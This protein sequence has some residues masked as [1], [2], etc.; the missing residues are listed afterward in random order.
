M[1]ARKELA[2]FGAAYLLYN[3]GRWVTNGDMGLALSNA[4]A[5]LDLQGG[6]GV[7]HAV[8][9]ALGGVW[10]T[11]LSHVYLAAQI[12]VLPGALLAIYRWAPRIYPRLRST[13]IATWMLSL[14]VYALFP[15]A[16]PR[17]AG[18]GM[19]DAVSETSAVALAGHSTIFYNPIAAVPSLHCG[20]AAALSIAV[21]A[22]VKRRWLKLAVL[23]WG[24]LVALSTV[25]TGNHYVF[26][27]AA[28][29]VV[30]ALGYLAVTCSL[31][32]PVLRPQVAT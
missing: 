27:V 5:V 25:A 15:V 13:V 2:L 26:D 23:A 24:P 14:P 1:R 3:A 22:A 20:F 18:I 7:E 6:D 32:I 28:G 30:T 17:L 19:D 21:A 9:N 8:Q 4:Q 10:M 31:R 12:I 11:L 29:L 16:P